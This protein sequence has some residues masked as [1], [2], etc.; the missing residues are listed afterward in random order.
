[1]KKAVL[2]VTALFAVVTA[3]PAMAAEFSFGG[4]MRYRYT[5]GEPGS[6]GNGFTEPESSVS[7]MEYRVRQF[8]N[9]KVNDHVTVNTK[10]EWN[11][12]FGDQGGLNGAN[13][14]L[15]VAGETELRIKNAFVRFDLPGTPVTLTVGQQD[16]STPKAI[17]SVED[18][19]G[20]K[21][22]F[23]A[24]GGS[25]SL[26]WARLQDGNA[27]DGLTPATNIGFETS[28][29]DADWFGFVPSFKFGDVNV[30]PH[31][32]YVRAG[33][34][35]VDR[36]FGD[37]L[38]PAVADGSADAF[39]LGVDTSGKLGPVGFTGDLIY[40]NGSF[41]TDVAD[42]DFASWIL[43]VSASLAA[44]PG[45][46]TIKGIYSPGD[47]NDADTD[48]D[49]WVNVISTDLGWSPLFHDGASASNFA[50]SVLPG[51]G[52]GGI[53]AVG[54]EYALSPYKD[55]TVT[56]NAYYLMAAED[57]NLSGDPLAAPDD[58][59]GIEAGVQANW[60][61]WDSVV[62][63]AQLDYLFAGDAFEDSAG[64][65]DDTWRL[66]VGPSISW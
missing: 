58:F 25:H 23:N 41:S 48:I 7:L 63:L 42:F 32:S 44:G 66:I 29:D 47:D 12:F 39:F 43:D 19:T 57:V 55:L 17:I 34:V 10:L 45:T 46:L 21:A 62:I 9:L 27:T 60:R 54:V 33:Q 49:N 30:S 38:D 8:F 35:A 40:Q 4:Y 28:V 50:G 65:T 16:F 56:P 11:S 59:Y 6:M 53:M 1:M 14:D 64:N 52:T 2:A 24:L 36:A 13:G 37:N 22:T 3:T 18:Y 61:V 5:T 26:F 20:I 51:R 15:Q 31:L